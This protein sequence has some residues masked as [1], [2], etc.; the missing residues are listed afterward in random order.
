VTTAGRSPQPAVAPSASNAGRVLTASVQAAA[1]GAAILGCYL[2][3]RNTRANLARQSIVSGF[4]FLWRR[5]GFDI[6]PHLVAYGPD[7]TFARALLVGVLNTLLLSV[8][9]IA[10]ATALG[11][12]IGLARLSPNWL[13]RHLAAGY[14]EIFRNVP[15]LLQVFFWYFGVL[16]TLPGPR[17]SIDLF[18]LLFLN[19]R[20]LYVPLPVARPG[21]GLLALALAAAAALVVLRRRRKPGAPGAA[22]GDAALLVGAPAAV[23]AAIG[24]PLTWE[25]PRLAA[26]D[27]VGGAVLNPELVAIA[28]GLSAYQAAFIAETVRG[29]VLSVPRGQIEA[30]SSLGLRRGPIVRHVVIPQALK[31]ILPPLVTIYLSTI[32]SSSLGAAIGYPELVSVFAGTTLSLVGQAVEIMAITLVIYLAIGLAVSCAVNAWD[33]RLRARE[34]HGALPG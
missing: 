4:D 34:G 2:I 31:A 3:Y 22:W 1:V 17:E 26:F 20:G 27:F 10:A 29:G 11:F 33:W 16:R 6:T 15:L 19:N 12:V 21:L 32:K 25:V 23:I 24:L 14:V 13:A 30:A 9:A 28:L 18:G 5:A 7:S 8:I